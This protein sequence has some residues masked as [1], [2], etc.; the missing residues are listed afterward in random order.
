MLKQVKNREA[1]LAIFDQQN[2]AQLPAVR[3]HEQPMLLTKSKINNLGYKFCI[4]LESKVPIVRPLS[5]RYPFII[6]G[7]IKA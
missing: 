2:P 7:L 5:G 6:C 1:V 4:V 3:I